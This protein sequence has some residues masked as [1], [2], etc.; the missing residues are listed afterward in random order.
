VRIS[1]AAL[2]YPILRVKWRA[3]IVGGSMGDD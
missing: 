3:L 1:V 2:V